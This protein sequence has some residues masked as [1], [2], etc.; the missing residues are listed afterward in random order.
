MKNEATMVHRT[1]KKSKQRSPTSIFGDGTSLCE[2]RM[3]GAHC[4]RDGDGEPVLE[5]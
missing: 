1:S 3:A 4:L 2:S 5:W